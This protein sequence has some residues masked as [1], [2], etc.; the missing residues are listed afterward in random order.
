MGAAKP[1]DPQNWTGR[2]VWAPAFQVDNFG[3]ATGSG[4]S[5]IAGLLTGFL[6]G[7]SIEESLQ[8]A[9]CLGW[10]NVQVLDAVSGIHSWNESNEF[11]KRNMPVIEPHI[12]GNGWIFSKPHGLYAGPNDPLA[13]DS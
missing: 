11:L 2:E 10:Q 1:A 8:Y 6:R 9:V 5:S 13:G 7:L 12:E 3:S 4:D